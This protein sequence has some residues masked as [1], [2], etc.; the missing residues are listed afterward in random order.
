MWAIPFMATAE[1]VMAYFGW[2]CPTTGGKEGILFITFPDG[3]PTGDAFVLLMRRM[4]RMCW[5]RMRTCWVEDILNSSGAQHQFNRFIPSHSTSNPSH[6]SS[7]PQQFMLPTDVGDC[8][9][10]WGLPYVATTEDILDF[11]PVLCGYSY[12]WGPHGIESPGRPIRRCL[13]PEEVCRKSIYDCAECY[14]KNPTFL[15]L[16]C[17]RLFGGTLSLWL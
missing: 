13:Y 12:T 5:G 8:V 1:E 2:Y 7:T 10:L 6:Y 16:T 15:L 4:H 14:K 9:C 17:W 11:L 3:R